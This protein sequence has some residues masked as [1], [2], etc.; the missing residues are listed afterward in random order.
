MATITSLGAGT[1]L[2]LET[3]LKGL[4]DANQTTLDGIT[5]RQKSYEVKISSFSQLQSSVQSVLDAS[6][7]LADSKTLNAVKS[8]VTGKGV[9]LTTQ[10]GAAPGQYSVT[11]DRLAK[12]Q[13]LQSAAVD[14]T[15]N[16]GSGGTIEIELRNGDKSTITLEENT[17]LEEVAKAIN[18]SDEAGVYATVINNG[19]GGSHLML[20]S[21]QTGVDNAVTKITVTGNDGDLD[22]ILS[23][24]AA[25]TGGGLT[26]TQE[27]NDAELTINGIDV[28]SSGNSISDVIDGVTINL[29]A[30]VEEGSTVTI[31]ITHDAAALSG[32]VTK[33]VNAYNSLQTTI[34]NLT[35]FD[36]EAE[37]QSALTGDST[38]RGIQTSLAAALQVVSDEGTVRTL[39]Q[40][41][42]TINPEKVGGA[43]GTLS[44][45]QTKLDEALKENPGDVARLL[46]G[47]NGL[48]ASIKKATDSML[49]AE[50]SIATRQDGLR[51]TVDSLQE[52]HDNTE[53]RLEGELD[54]MRA[55]FVNL[56][57]LVAQMESTSSYLTQQ[58][59]N[60]S[61]SQNR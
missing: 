29:A 23:Y 2:D 24:D 43:G 41:G 19:S 26:Q 51:N 27:A 61:S 10:A 22:Q 31:D 40:L 42:I 9:S 39:A 58:F 44:I 52:Q 3:I 16:H 15:E 53:A 47:P 56:S 57:V 32:A 8:S 59:A 35:K 36:V 28:T 55:Q 38:A 54:I 11:V 48:S 37:T 18:A 20:T 45:D 49:G 30:D 13:R 17:S 46:A 34:Y 12:S 14:R 1:S 4:Q 50:G 21:K 33:F 6:N 25:T 60:M 5:A 7:A